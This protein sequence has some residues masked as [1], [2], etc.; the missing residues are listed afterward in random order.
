[1]IQFNRFQPIFGQ[2][3]Q[4]KFKINYDRDNYC[5]FKLKKYNQ[6]AD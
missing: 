5:L 2:N 1:M 6:F 4:K 3:N